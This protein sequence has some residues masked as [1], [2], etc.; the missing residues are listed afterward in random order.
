MLGILIYCSY[1][2]LLTPGGRKSDTGLLWHFLARGVGLVSWALVLALC[3][4]VVGGPRGIKVRSV[5]WLI[6]FRLCDS[7]S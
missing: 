6:C 3:L 1:G 7:A 5:A 2:I 4:S